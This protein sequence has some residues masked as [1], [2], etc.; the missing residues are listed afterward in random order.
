M[1][2]RPLITKLAREDLL[3]IWAY[4]AQDSQTSADR[5]LDRVDQEISLLC[6]FP[7]RGE[8]DSRLGGYRRILLGSYLLF[9]E[10]SE[11]D[12]HVLRVFHASRRIEDLRLK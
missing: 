1:K 12:L 10:V 7:F 2:L 9:Y 8:V 5:F 4:I 6:T 3:S 11:G